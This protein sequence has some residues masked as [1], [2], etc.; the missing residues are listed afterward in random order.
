MNVNNF[1]QGLFEDTLGLDIYGLENRYTELVKLIDRR[2]LQT[3]GNLIPAYYL[4]YLDLSDQ[5]HIVKKEHHTEGVE[6]YIDDP[7]LDKFRLPIL[8]IDS[9]NYNNVGNVDPYDPDSTAF[10]SSVL[11]SR[12]NVTLESVLMGSEYTYSRTLIDTGMPYKRYNEFRGGRILYLRNWGYNGSIEIK[13]KTKWPNIVSIPEEYFEIFTTLAKYDVQIKLW[14][15]LKY[16]EDVT[17]PNGNLQLRFDW[18]GAERDREDYL[19]ELRLK[20]LPDRV[21]PVY[22]HIL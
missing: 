17:T 19:K 13:I 10:Y 12:N 3:F 8:G 22:F 6:Y 9:I 21:G 2:T 5:S 20:S 4:T 11:A 18:S 14:N 7:V 16:L 15:E 1:Y